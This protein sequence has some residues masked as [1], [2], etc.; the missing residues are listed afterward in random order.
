ML[1]RKHFQMIAD[2]VSETR[3]CDP[4]EQTTWR[5]ACDDL[6]RTLAN[7]L[8]TTNPNFNRQRFLEACGVE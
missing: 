7:K 1:T 2:A 6:S 8:A 5:W 3:S 4:G